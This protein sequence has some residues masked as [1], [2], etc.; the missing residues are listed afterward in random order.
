MSDSC[1]SAHE[2][3]ILAHGPVPQGIILK[4]IWQT[5]KDYVGDGYTSH[6]APFRF[7]VHLCET[8]RVPVENDNIF[9]GIHIAASVW[10]LGRDIQAALHT[11]SIDDSY[12]IF[13]RKDET[14]VEETRKYAMRDALQWWVTWHDGCLSRKDY[15]KHLYVGFGTVCDDIL[16][17]TE[18]LVDG[19]FRFLGHTLSEMC[20]WRQFVVQY[21][22]KID[23]KLRELLLERTHVMSQ[24]HVVTGNTHGCAALV[25]AARGVAC[26]DIGDPVVEMAAYGCSVSLTLGKECLGILKGEPTET[27][28]ARDRN[29]LDAE[30][31]WVY[32]RSMDQL[33]THEG[34]RYLRRYASAGFLFVA[35]DDRCQERR[36]GRRRR[37]LSPQMRALI[38]SYTVGP[39]GL[40]EV[41]VAQRRAAVTT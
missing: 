41:E 5:V 13:S 34:A 27:T 3:P 11:A 21:I 2:E 14:S 39:S 18:H 23:P 26:N 12:K 37:M 36:E 32:A 9:L 38:A 31:R 16:I 15:W 40:V 25:L 17:P 19:I 10:G 35:L 22:E 6:S 20:L 8:H 33:D 4:E 24:I 30:L 7:D 29:R 28:E 1:H